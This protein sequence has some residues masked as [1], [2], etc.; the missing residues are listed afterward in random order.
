LSVGFWAFLSLRSISDPTHHHTS[1]P[2]THK[3][4]LKTLPFFTEA[5]SVGHREKYGG[6]YMTIFKHMS[7]KQLIKFWRFP[8]TKIFSNFFFPSQV[9]WDLWKKIKLF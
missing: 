5:A 1:I 8:S 3:R 7:I 9:F 2:S 6:L 4:F